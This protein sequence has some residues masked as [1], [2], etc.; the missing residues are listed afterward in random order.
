M[1]LEFVDLLGHCGDHRV[2]RVGGGF[3]HVALALDMLRGVLDERG[4]RTA[5]VPGLA[6]EAVLGVSNELVMGRLDRLQRGDLAGLEGDGRLVTG[7]ALAF[8]RGGGGVLGEGD[9]ADFGGL[10]GHG[11]RLLVEVFG[12]GQV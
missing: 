1:L 2:R 3:E 7:I 9:A 12:P 10:A 11:G 8:G 4:E 6:R 5:P